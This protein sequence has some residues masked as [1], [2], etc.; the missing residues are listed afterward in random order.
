MKVSVSASQPG[1]SLE[2]IIKNQGMFTICITNVKPYLK[3]FLITALITDTLT[4][5]S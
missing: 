4:K 3:N 1:G 5:I 2:F